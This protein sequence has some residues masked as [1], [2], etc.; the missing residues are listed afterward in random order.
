[1]AEKVEKKAKTQLKA[2]TTRGNL[3]MIHLFGKWCGDSKLPMHVKKP[4]QPEAQARMVLRQ[5]Y[6]GLRPWPQPPR[7]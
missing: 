6:L 7:L 3:K 2:L 1:M 5:Q 4:R